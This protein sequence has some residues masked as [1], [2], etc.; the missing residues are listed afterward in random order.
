MTHK[1][2]SLTIVRAAPP[3]AL[4]FASSAGEG[5]IEGLASTFGGSPDAHGDVVAL[6]AF[7]ETLNEM[8]AR[9]ETP[10]ML[11]SH[12]PDRPI[13]RWTE[14][15]TSPEGLFVAGRLNLETSAGRD[16]HAHLKAGDLS[17]L[18]IGYRIAPGG[19]QMRA[20]GTRL[21]TALDLIE[22]SVVAIPANPAA[23]VTGVKSFGSKAELETILREVLPGRAVKKLMSG[24]WSALSADEGEPEPTE[25]LSAVYRAIKSARAQLKEGFNQ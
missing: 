19:S 1:L 20:D 22:V 14:V 6:S 11:W 4:K 17:G 13:G 9:G 24:G 8:R 2:D 12:D 3:L 25:D 5:L 15:R 16:A 21:L 7:D 23:R 18:S 10:L